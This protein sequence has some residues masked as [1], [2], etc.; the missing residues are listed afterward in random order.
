MKPKKFRLDKANARFGSGGHRESG[1]HLT[2]LERPR[3]G[4]ETW[5]GRCN[6]LSPQFEIL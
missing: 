3:Y 6:D 4:G 5:P 2:Q 1:T